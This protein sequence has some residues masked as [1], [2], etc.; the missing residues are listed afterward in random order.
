[1]NSKSTELNII[2]HLSSGPG[3]LVTLLYS[4]CSQELQSECTPDISDSAPPSKSIIFFPSMAAYPL[5]C[6]I[7]FDSLSIWTLEMCKFPLHEWS[8][9]GLTRGR[10]KSQRDQVQ[11]Q[12]LGSRGTMELYPFKF[13]EIIFTKFF[14]VERMG[15]S[16]L[17]SDHVGW[18]SPLLVL[19]KA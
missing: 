17:F 3:F 11:T 9:T 12:N 13:L 7:F 6:I 19:L 15:F 14:L 5:L 18:L 2:D 8:G 1:M 16:F 10:F 4:Q